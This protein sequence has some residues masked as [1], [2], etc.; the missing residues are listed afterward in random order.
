MVLGHK[1]DSGKKIFL[2]SICVCLF[3]TYFWSLN[4]LLPD[5]LT[6]L[7]FIV[8]Y[9]LMY[10]DQKTAKHIFDHFLILLCASSHISNVPL[11]VVALVFFLVFRKK[12]HIP[13]E[14]RYVRI[15]FAA[16]AV[17]LGISYLIMSSAISKSKAIFFAGNLAQKGIFQKYLQKVCSTEE[18]RLCNFKDS[19]P[20]S[21]EYFVW[22][23]KSPLYRLGGWK[24]MRHELGQINTGCLRDP[25]L[26]RDYFARSFIQVQQQLKMFLIGEGNGPFG[27]GTVLYERIQKYFCFD[28]RLSNNSFQSQ[29]AMLQL[30]RLNSLYYILGIFTFVVFIGTGIGM[31]RRSSAPIKG[32]FLMTILLI[33]ANSVLVSFSSEISHRHGCKLH[34][35]M[36]VSI[37]LIV[38]Q[39][40]KRQILLAGSNI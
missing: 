21:F 37:F 6:A 15:K 11:Y 39:R 13:G 31:L 12:M 26:L 19:L 8:L 40:C 1:E 20:F 5:F 16:I 36:V 25:Q 4:L 17:L 10:S 38:V 32:F 3:S 28:H 7:G 34:W 30:N 35:L 23:E 22:N 27:Q 29:G 33:A 18:Y 9:T 14:R 2:L 24:T